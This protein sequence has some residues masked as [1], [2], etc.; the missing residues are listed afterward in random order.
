MRGGFGIY[1]DQVLLNVPLLATIFEPG[2]FNFQ[3][4]LFPGYPDP[5]VGRQ[6]GA[7]SASAQH[8]D[9][10]S[11]TTQTPYKNVGSLGVQRE[12]DARHGRS[13]R[14]SSTPVA[15]TCSMLRDNNAPTQGVYPDPNIGVA[16]EPQTRGKGEY[17]AFQLGFTKRF[18][19]TLR[20]P[21]RLHP[22]AATETIR[23]ARS[24][25]RA[26]TSTSTPTTAR[27]SN[28]IRNTLN[29]AVDW[30]GPWGI[31][32]G[33]SGSLLSSPPFNIITGN[34]DN[35]DTYISDRPA[36]EKRNSGRGA[37]LWTVNLRLAKS[38]LIGPTD[39]QLIVEAFNLFNHVNPTN[40]IGEHAVAAVRQAHVRGSGGVRATPDPV[41]PQ[42]RLLREGN[43]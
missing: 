38:I 36:G 5:L 9:P 26:T 33:A 29:A 22:G 8:L 30:R 16:Y 24:T 4:I 12:L 39:L 20:R 40:Y 41:R 42:T 14:T 37:T 25:R 1:Y 17:M 6:P 23:T 7:D 27:A 19:Q 15:T 21:A 13:A 31:V 28:D 10:R 34:D 32:V 2:R 35:G 3:T 18:G 43:R 11:A